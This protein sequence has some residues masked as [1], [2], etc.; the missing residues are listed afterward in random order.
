MRFVAEDLE[1]L[2]VFGNQA[3]V[4]IENSK[5]YNKE[6]EEDAR[7]REQELMSL[8][9]DRTRNLQVE[10]EKAEK[11]MSVAEEAN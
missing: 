10:K 6:F 4:A 7:S 3:A 2:S 8:V 5:L 11:A 9:D 1:F